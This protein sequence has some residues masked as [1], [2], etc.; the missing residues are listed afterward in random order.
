[1][2]KGSLTRSERKRLAEL[3][4]RCWLPSS[5]EKS[6]LSL[7]IHSRNS[8]NLDRGSLKWLTDFRF[9]ATTENRQSIAAALWI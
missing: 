5:H 1:V 2:W 7:S 9:E 8:R 4:W 6:G 3:R